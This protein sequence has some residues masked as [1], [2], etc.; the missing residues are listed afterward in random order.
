MR[1]AS[2]E[3]C[4]LLFAKSSEEMRTD[5]FLMAKANMEVQTDVDKLVEDNFNLEQQLIDAGN[6]GLLLPGTK[7]ERDEAEELLNKELAATKRALEDAK[8]ARTKVTQQLSC[9][10]E[11]RDVLLTRIE[12]LDQAVRMMHVQ[13]DLK[14]ARD[15]LAAERAQSHAPRSVLIKHQGPEHERDRANWIKCRGTHKVIPVF[16]RSDGWVWNTHISKMEAELRIKEI[17]SLKSLG[18]Q[19]LHQQGKTNT[20]LQEYFRKYLHK[21]FH[22]NSHKMLEFSYNFVATLEKHIIDGDFSLFLKILFND[23]NEKH[24]YDQMMMISNLKAQF[25]KM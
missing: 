23:V 5:I 10:V 9:I 17:W 4:K 15:D 16:L 21:R 13:V 2:R 18:D 1:Y 20:S 8:M 12:V 11:D 25:T 19:I 7:Q 24:F 14:T 22:G 6:N 3:Y